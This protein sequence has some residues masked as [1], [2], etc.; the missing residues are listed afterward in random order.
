MGEAGREIR[1]V[2]LI[3]AD[4]WPWIIDKYAQLGESRVFSAVS[5]DHCPRIP[6]GTAFEIE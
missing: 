1:C 2:G 6:M 4:Q 3:N 5:G